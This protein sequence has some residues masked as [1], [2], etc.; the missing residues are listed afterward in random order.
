MV[1]SARY[2]S[3][4]E[5]ALGEIDGN[6]HVNAN[7]RMPHYCTKLNN[8]DLTVNWTGN[9]LVNFTLTARTEHSPPLWIAVGFSDDRKMVC[10]HLFD[11]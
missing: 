1:N 11:L 2:S 5:N 3:D 8:C 7:L 10:M 6:E 9:E 4:E